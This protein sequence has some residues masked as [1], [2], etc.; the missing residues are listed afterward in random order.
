MDKSLLDESKQTNLFEYVFKNALEPDIK[1]IVRNNNK[2][3]VIT[4]HKK[5]LGPLNP[6]LLNSF[7][8][9]PGLSKMEILD[10]D[11]EAFQI[12]IDYLYT[13]K[14]SDGN[15]T[16][17][18]LLVAHKYA[19]PTLKNVCRQKLGLNFNSENAARRLLTF[20]DCKEKKLIRGASMFL[21]KNY[22]DVKNRFEFRQVLQKPEAISAIF[23]VFGKNF[24]FLIV[25]L[26]FQL[27]LF[28]LFLSVFNFYIF[29]FADECD[30]TVLTEFK[31]PTRRSLFE[32][33][34]KSDLTIKVQNDYFLA[35]KN[36]L[37]SQNY[38]LKNLIST[39]KST[40]NVSSS[41]NIPQFDSKTFKIFL[42]YVYTGNVDKNDVS[43]ELLIVAHK[44][45]DL[46]LSKIC[47]NMLVSTV[48]EENAVDLLILSTEVESEKLKEGAS[49]FIA[50]NY[51]EM[52]ERV[53]FQNVKTNPAAV[54]AIFQQFAIL[55]QSLND[56]LTNHKSKKQKKSIQKLT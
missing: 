24:I 12:F 47:E 16:E 25:F 15:I 4:G 51:I 45:F 9:Q 39:L 40:K 21:A 29:L 11:A 37:S 34:T 7:L 23:D 30:V 52:K 13:G 2:D 38:I 22:N 27:I 41:L 54:D 5:I 55:N 48:C 17:E 8:S 20:L 10:L 36:V 14:I 6:V 33:A 1:F 49:K 32:A 44:Y 35:H 42:Q 31:N 26:I 46:K 53:E 18:L 19:D 50:D 28:I 56:N 43:N 3:K